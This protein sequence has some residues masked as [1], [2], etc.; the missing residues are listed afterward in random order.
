MA[1]NKAWFEAQK[2]KKKEEELARL[3]AENPDYIPPIETTK[4]ENSRTITD[5]MIFMSMRTLM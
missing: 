5:I 1:F 4:I 2:Q 3:K